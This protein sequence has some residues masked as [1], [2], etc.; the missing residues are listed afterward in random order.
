MFTI[1]WIDE[2]RWEGT[3]FSVTV[4]RPATNPDGQAPSKQKRE[5]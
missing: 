2:D 1:R 4:V 5:I 3:D